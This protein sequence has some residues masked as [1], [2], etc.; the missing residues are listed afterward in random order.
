MKTVFMGTPDFAVHALQALYHS[1]H[2]VTAVVTLPDKRSGRGRKIKPFPVKVFAREHGLPVVQPDSLK[3]PAFLDQ[4]KAFKADAFIVV[5]FRILPRSVFEIPPYGTINVHAS[6]LPAYRGAAPINW[7]IINGEQETGVTTMRIDA[8]VDTGD[9]LLQKRTPILPDMNAGTLHDILAEMGAG[10]LIDTLDGLEK[11]RLEPQKQDDR[12]A[13][14]AP[15]LTPHNT[16][17]DFRRDAREVHNFIRGLAPYPGAYTGWDG[18]KLKILAA[19]PVADAPSSAMPGEVIALG[20]DHLTVACGKGGIA[21]QQLQLQGKKTMAV[22]D[23]LNGY[24]LKKGTVL[25]VIS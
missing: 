8:R 17:I 14:P 13:C 9:I 16:R 10:L 19:L 21:V 1:S 11:G 24:T 25:N 5:A 3:D 2:D 4:L 15:K 7:A 12:L 22:R 23:F 18:K 6:L 20:K